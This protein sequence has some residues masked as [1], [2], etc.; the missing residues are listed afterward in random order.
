MDYQ[1]PIREFKKLGI[2]GFEEMYSKAT[3]NNLFDDLETGNITPEKFR[4]EI[5]GYAG[6]NISDETIDF[7]WN[8]IL[9]D[10]PHERMEMLKSLRHKYR[11]FLL[12][13]TNAIHI[14]EF[15]QIL[16]RTFGKNV[17]DEVF[18]KYYYSSDIKMRKPDK[19]IFEYVIRENHL[20]PAETLFIDDS[21]QHVEGAAS[22]GLQTVWLDVRKTDTIAVLTKMNLL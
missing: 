17:F 13:N 10:F 19:E 9:L 20:D 2:E 3:Q 15:H 8:S 18:E 1:N 14:K 12:S 5:R 4:N 22:C 21:P 7:A 16:A 6:K 11:I